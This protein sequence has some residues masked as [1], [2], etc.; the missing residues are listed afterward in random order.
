VLF[1][2]APPKQVGELGGGKSHQKRA[3][4]KK[5][6]RALRGVKGSGRMPGKWTERENAIDRAGM[7]PCGTWSPPSGPATDSGVREVSG[8]MSLHVWRGRHVAMSEVPRAGRR[9]L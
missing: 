8:P 7:L 1:A 5:S 4:L 9:L 6:R 2:L 3:C